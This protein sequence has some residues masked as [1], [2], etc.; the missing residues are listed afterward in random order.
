[1]L[2]PSGGTITVTMRHSPACG[3][4]LQNVE[5]AELRRNAGERA[6]LLHQHVEHRPANRAAAIAQED[7]AGN[8]A[9]NLEPG[10]QHS[11]FP[12]AEMMLAGIRAFQPVDE[13]AFR[14]R[15]VV[16]QLELANLRGPQSGMIC[17]AEDGAIT[18]RLNDAEEP[19]DLLE[20]EVRLLAFLA[21]VALRRVRWHWLDFG[22]WDDLEGGDLGV[23]RFGM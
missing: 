1:M 22:F 14:A 15:A 6:I 5:V 23:S 17:H 7:G 10:A 2:S 4:V 9:T 21:A 13:D 16:P 8:R 18:R 3:I 11:A 19:V 12:A 20:L